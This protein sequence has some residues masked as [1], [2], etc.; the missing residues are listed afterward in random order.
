MHALCT[1]TYA[2]IRIRTRTCLHIA[3]FQVI[4]VCACARVLCVRV[5]TCV[6]VLVC[7]FVCVCVYV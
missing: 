1:Y 4:Y 2:C 5:C 3:G 7:A 6:A